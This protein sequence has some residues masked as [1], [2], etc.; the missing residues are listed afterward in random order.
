MRKHEFEKPAEQPMPEL[1]PKWAGYACKHCHKISG[2]DAWQ[3]RDMPVEMA[4]C[5]DGARRMG[6]LERA[7]GSVNCMAPK[8]GK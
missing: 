1:A 6:L 4:R 8:E 2:L 7:R 3:I 5:P